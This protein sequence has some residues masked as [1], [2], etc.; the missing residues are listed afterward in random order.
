MKRERITIT[1]RG[2]LLKTLDK[3]IDGSQLRNRSQAIEHLLG[4]SLENKPPQALILAGGKQIRF[5]HLSTSEIPKAM[6]PI[7]GSPLLE[8]TIRR[9]KDFGITDITISVGA[10]GQKIKDHFRDG[11]RFDVNIKYLEQST[12]KKGTAQALL[13]AGANFSSKPFFLLY[14][15]VL[16]DVNYFDLLEFHKLHQGTLCTMMVTSVDLVKQ[17]GV[18]RLAGSRIVEFQE[19]P[20]SPLTKSHLVNAGVYVLEPNIVDYINKNDAKL[21]LTTLPRLAEEGRL[22]GYVYEGNW[23]DVST[24]ETYRQA[25]RF[26]RND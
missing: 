7:N 14:G 24:E 10:G 22:G 4:Q 5:K 1:V 3:E 15:D 12:T 13:G 16:T 8:F 21:E 23:F 26:S 2:D 25:L 20:R 11:K 19:K 18:A 9:L 6:L 17:W